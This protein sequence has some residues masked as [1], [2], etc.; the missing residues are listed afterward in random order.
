MTTA[1]GPAAVVEDE[2]RRIETRLAAMPLDRLD[3]PGPDAAGR[4]RAE[5]FASALQRL[6]D[7]A[8]AA[9][10]LPPCP[11]PSLRPHAW[12]AQLRVFAHD[13]RTADRTGAG[14]ARAADVLAALRR[15]L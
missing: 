12:T 4:T 11:V 9:E 3:R 14:V 5:A 6:A 15:A 13:L 8:R 1:E 2:L 10:G 7:L